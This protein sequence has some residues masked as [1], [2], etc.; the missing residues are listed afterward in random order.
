M[1]KEKVER[2]KYVEIQKELANEY[3]SKC[4]S[5][6]GL[7]K[8]DVRE[9]KDKYYKEFETKLDKYEVLDFDIDIDNKNL[10]HF[11][12]TYFDC[13]DK[14]YDCY[15]K[16][17]GSGTQGLLYRFASKNNFKSIYNDCYASCYYSKEDM[18]ILS[19][20]EGDI[21]CDVFYDEK[22]FMQSLDETIIFYENEY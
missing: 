13:E 7:N 19:Y 5:L 20:C 6:A 18:C 22:T 8:E 10:I 16:F 15:T 11:I 21:T 14:E 4:L 17:T 3:V 12:N 2:N 1:M 9:L